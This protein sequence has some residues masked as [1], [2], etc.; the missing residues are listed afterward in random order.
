MLGKKL[1]TL[2]GR[3]RLEGG[4]VE[5]SLEA[6]TVIQY[7]SHSVLSE[8]TTQM[9]LTLWA[10][11]LLRGR[12]WGGTR[13]SVDSVHIQVLRHFSFVTRESEE[14]HLGLAMNSLS[15]L[16]NVRFLKISIL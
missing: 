13:S 2:V 1:A 8:H 10:G 11:N 9:L 6:H 3:L 7:C 4:M 16:G 5:M 14:Q 15:V 12:I